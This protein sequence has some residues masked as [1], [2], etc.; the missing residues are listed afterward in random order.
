MHWTK[1]T[2]YLLVLL[3]ELLR[4]SGRHTLPSQDKVR[5]ICVIPIRHLF[6]EWPI[7]WCG[8]LV[9]ASAYPL[10]CLVLTAQLNRNL[11]RPNGKSSTPWT[12]LRK[13]SS[14][15]GISHCT[16]LE[17]VVYLKHTPWCSCVL[18]IIKRVSWS[19][20]LDRTMAPVGGR[21]LG[22]VSLCIF[23]RN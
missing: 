10:P 14:D 7:A 22:L 3:M 16:H 19:S 9:V 6:I 5:H 1:A 18:V 15:V 8:W 12:R 17:Q 20:C 21:D 2:M 11:Q 4:V 13:T 23:I